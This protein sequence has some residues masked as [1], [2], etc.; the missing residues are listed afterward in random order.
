M[1]Y[2]KNISFEKTEIEDFDDLVAWSEIENRHLDMRLFEKQG[3][4]SVY[5]SYYCKNDEIYVKLFIVYD[6]T[7]GIAWSVFAETETGNLIK[8][9]SVEYKELRS[10]V[11]EQWWALV[12]KNR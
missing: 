4:G 6:E 10:Y 5:E 3:V 7:L 1:D 8:R 9:G 2:L 12:R 11:E